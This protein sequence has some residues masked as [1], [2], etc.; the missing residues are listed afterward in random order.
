MLTAARDVALTTHRGLSADGR[1]RGRAGLTPIDTRDPGEM[2]RAIA[3]FA[4][5]PN[6]GLIAADV[7]PR[8]VRD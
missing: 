3:A 8:C 2:E 4:R 5:E 6:G 7:A 1:F